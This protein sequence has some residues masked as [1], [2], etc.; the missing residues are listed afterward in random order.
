[1]SD[2][3][4]SAPAG[5]IRLISL[6]AGEARDVL[7]VLPTHPRRDDVTA[8]LVE[9]DAGIAARAR[10]RAAEAGLTSVEVVT[11]DAALV[12]A[13]ADVAPADVVL[14]CGIFGNVDESDI[15]ATIEGLRQL[16]RPGAI[17]LWTRHHK[18]PDLTPSIR[19]WFAEAGF[20]EIGFDIEDGHTFSVGS[21]RFRGPTPPL[22]PGLRLFEFLPHKG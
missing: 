9:I 7:G 4:D 6:C 21:Q 22:D 8:R 1:L 3:L 5:P 10:S 11:G 18:E 14:A 17:V 20:D 16:S 19:N 13:Y 2:G 12:S 15:R